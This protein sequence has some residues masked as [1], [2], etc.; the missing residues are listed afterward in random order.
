MIIATNNKGKIEEIKKIL[1]IKDIYSLKEKNINVDVEEDQDTFLENAKKKAKEI[2]DLTKEA[3]LADDSGLAITNL[4]GFPGVM[5][6][7]FLGNN[8]TDT[9]RNNALIEKANKLK[10]R[11]AKVICAIAY[12][13]GKKYITAEGVIDGKIALEK[14]GNNGFG[15]DEIFELPNGKTLA[16]LSSLEKNEISARAIAL[17]KLKEKL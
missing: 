6:H 2:Y 3:T 13:D 12:Y 9:Q 1:D 15:F 16:E 4:S 14:R 17:K 11:S 8:A 5:T 10:D 7:R